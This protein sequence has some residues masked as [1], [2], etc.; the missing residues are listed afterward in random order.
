MSEK[1]PPDLE[2]EIGIM[3]RIVKRSG[4][5]DHAKAIEAGMRQLALDNPIP[6][7]I[8]SRMARDK[9]SSRKTLLGSC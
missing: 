1:N 3:R 9:T 5:S 4:I 2:T 6:D 8:R 7:H